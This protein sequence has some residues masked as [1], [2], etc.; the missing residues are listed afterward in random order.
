MAQTIEALHRGLWLLNQLLAVD[1]MVNSLSALHKRTGIP[2]ASL[3]AMLQTFE[4]AG[5]VENRDN[6]WQISMV[7][8]LKVQ[9]HNVR[10]LQLQ[11]ERISRV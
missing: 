10:R 6:S 3:L 2:K 4:A 11:L 7:W 9:T 5:I 1:Y 8:L